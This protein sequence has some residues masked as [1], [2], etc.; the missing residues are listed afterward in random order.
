M[1]VLL[2]PAAGGGNGGQDHAGLRAY[3]DPV[4]FRDDRVLKTL[5]RKEA[6][7]RPAHPNYF[8]IQTEIQPHM[9]KEVADWMMEV[10]EDRQCQPEVFCLAMNYLDRF[11]SLCRIG[12]SQL[13]L[14]GAVCLL[15]ACKV[16]EHEPLPASRLVEYSDYNLTLVDIMEW[17]VLLLSKLDWDMS[18]VIASDF[19]EHIIQRVRRL[20]FGWS[21]D[22]VRRHSEILVAMCSAHHTFSP[23]APSLVAA[24]C[25]LTTLR[26][27]LEAPTQDT[28]SP[29]SCSS[30]GSTT[31]RMPD[32]ETVLDA[33]ENITLLNKEVVKDCMDRIDLLMRADLPPSPMHSPRQARRLF[34]TPKKKGERTSPS[35]SSTSVASP[36]ADDTPT[37]VLDVARDC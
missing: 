7:Y 21:P 14:L 12:R 13:Q 11:L 30:A 28:P 4:I 35:T 10:C 31:S 25:V 5:L 3:S 16:R 9:R 37:K 33:V 23:M 22:V 8:S 29:S 15:V 17:E 20:P 26:P 34:E 32:I 1:S 18:A 19:V 27:L 36:I 2:P 24:A 6:K